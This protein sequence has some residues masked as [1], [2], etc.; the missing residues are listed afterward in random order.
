M[1]Y[2]HMTIY[3]LLTYAQ[4]DASTELEKALLNAALRLQADVEY[5]KDDDYNY[6]SCC[7]HELGR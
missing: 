4:T 5:Y 3:E 7:G 6:C 2:K 1:T